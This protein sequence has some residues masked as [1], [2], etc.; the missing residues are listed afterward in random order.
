MFRQRF[1]YFKFLCVFHAIYLSEETD[2]YLCP[3]VRSP[4]APSDSTHAGRASR[5]G[6][7]IP[8]KQNGCDLRILYYPHDTVK[9]AGNVG[10]AS[11]CISG[12]IVF[13][14]QVFSYLTS[15]SLFHDKL[16]VL[17]FGKSLRTVNLARERAMRIH[18]D[19]EVPPSRN[20]ASPSPSSFL[21]KSKRCR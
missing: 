3:S 15:V 16:T 9:K 18:L 13:F 6:S 17:I 21:A 2:P 10:V 11:Y 12:S 1:A 7:I 4:V 14:T 19:Q 5:W 20:R 8:E